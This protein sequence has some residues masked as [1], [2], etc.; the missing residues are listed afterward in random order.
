MSTIIKSYTV[1]L[2]LIMSVLICTGII[3]VTVDVQNARDYHAAC[4]NEIENSN[5]A[6]SVIEACK[7]EAAKNGY[8]L[9]VTS[10]VNDIDGIN[11]S[12][13]S[14][15]VLKYDYTIGLLSVNSEKEVI[16]YAR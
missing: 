10:Y 14:K 2:L 5:H 8:E 1:I 13:I 4:I 6:S 15:V 16:G 11:T 7:I 9:I 3:S 12:T